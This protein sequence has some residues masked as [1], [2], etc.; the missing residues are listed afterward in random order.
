MSV[1]NFNQ[2]RGVAF[3]PLP[4]GRGFHAITLDEKIWIGTDI[5]I[6]IV[7]VC[8]GKV[9]IGIEAPPHVIITRPDEEEDEDEYTA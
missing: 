4:K 3:P 8:G 7:R 9:R 6:T 2:I 5:E 1:K